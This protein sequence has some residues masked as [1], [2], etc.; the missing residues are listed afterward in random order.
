MSRRS[1]LFACA[2]GAALADL[3]WL[4][5]TA[6]PHGSPYPPRESRYELAAGAPPYA[7]TLGRLVEC[8][9]R[10]IWFVDN[11]SHLPGRWVLE[12]SRHNRAVVA[13]FRKRTIGR[14]PD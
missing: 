7:Q 8:G 12:A 6:F 13:C 1:N 14:G 5:M 3:A 10:Q 2:A 9:A 4:A 11:L